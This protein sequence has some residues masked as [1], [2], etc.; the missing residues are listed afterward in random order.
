[1]SP[2]VLVVEDNPVNRRIA[3]RML[4]RLG[5]DVGLADNG[6]IA[7]QLAQ[8]NPYDIIFMDCLMPELDGYEATRELRRLQEGK[9]RIPIIALTAH[10]TEEDRDRCLRAGM[11][12]YLTK[13]VSTESFAATLKA[14]LKSAV[15]C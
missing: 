1:M 15:A 14:W 5:C 9:V 2:R 8:A 11:D 3:Q 4:E 10:S 7:L 12:D 6:R 13:P